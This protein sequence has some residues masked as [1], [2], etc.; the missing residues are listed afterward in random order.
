MI[1]GLYML[2]TS[3]NLPKTSPNT[4]ENNEKYAPNLPPKRPRNIPKTSQNLSKHIPKTS[5]KYNL[6]G[7][8][9]KN[10]SV[11]QICVFSIF[12]CNLRIEGSHLSKKVSGRQYP[13]I[14]H[15]SH[16]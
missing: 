2:F 15:D 11:L 3:K 13:A 10:T 5:Q 14:P 6:L 4:F 8:V 7:V 12:P 16:Q 1:T 9:G